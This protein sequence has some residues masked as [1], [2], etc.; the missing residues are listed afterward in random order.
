MKHLLIALFSVLALGGCRAPMMPNAT[1]DLW[2][3]GDPVDVGWEMCG[4]GEFLVEDGVLKTTGGMGMLWYAAE[5]F[6]DFELSL[7]W[8]VKDASYNS[9]VFVRFPDP[10]QEPYV[11][12]NHGY[13]IQICD[14]AKPKHNTG[15]VYSFQ[16]ATS[17]PTFAVGMWNEMRIKVVGQHYEIFVNDQLVNT[18]EGNRS[19]HGFIGLQNHD[20]HSP[21]RFRNIRVTR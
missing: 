12:V 21:V 3:S 4:P 10:G 6:E 20:D 5:D 16:A 1:T 8:M 7:E 9:G 13:E 17:I 19:A 15:S 14:L 18:Y 2:V 11:A